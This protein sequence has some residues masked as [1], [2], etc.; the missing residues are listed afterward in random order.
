MKKYLIIIISLAFFNQKSYSQIK[1][2]KIDSI[3]IENGR[4]V[5][6][7][8]LANKTHMYNYLFMNF[9][10]KIIL[11]RQDSTSYKIFKGVNKFDIASQKLEISKLDSETVINN[12]ILDKC[13]NKNVCNP[14]FLY[15]GS[16]SVVYENSNFHVDCIYF[17]LEKTGRKIFEFNVPIT[18]QKNSSKDSEF[19]LQQRVFKYLVRLLFLNSD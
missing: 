12:H 1:M 10:E 17:I 9:R 4:N 19:P 3:A 18:R 15:V 2:A 7:K 8:V 16:D 13:F 11:I 5:I 6:N 14:P